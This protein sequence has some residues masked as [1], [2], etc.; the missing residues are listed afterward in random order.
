M[1]KGFIYESEN[2]EFPMVAL[3]F[4][5]DGLVIKGTA[6][7]DKPQG[8]EYIRETLIGLRQVLNVS[9]GRHASER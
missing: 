4:D 7:A 8:E 6:V 1:N 9:S 5:A 2:V 3:I